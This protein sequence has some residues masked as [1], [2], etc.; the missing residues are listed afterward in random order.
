MDAQAVY[1]RLQ[2][3]NLIV[4]DQVSWEAHGLLNEIA[5]VQRQTAWDQ[6]DTTAAQL[7]GFQRRKTDYPVL[8]LRLADG[9][10]QAGRL[11]EATDSISEAARILQVRMS[12]VDKQN[13]AVA[14]L[15]EGL[16]EHF[17]HQLSDAVPAYDEARFQFRLAAQEW[18]R[19]TGSNARIEECRRADAELE[20][21]V[22]E[23]LVRSTASSS[24]GQV[25]ATP[26]RSVPETLPLT[27][28]SFSQPRRGLDR[29]VPALGWAVVALVTVAL[30][31]VSHTHG[32]WAGL[33]AFL[34]AWLGTIAA[35]LVIGRT[36]TGGEFNLR[37]PYEHA[38]VVEERGHIH[39]LGPGS[40]W[41]LIPGIRRVRATVPLTESSF[42]LRK[43]RVSLGGTS[44]RE[45]AAQVRLTIQ[46][47]YQIAEPDRAALRF[48]GSLRAKDGA[49]TP[50]G[51]DDLRAAWE[52]RL[53]TDLKPLLADE[54]WGHEA[55]DCLAQRDLI[56]ANL[57]NLLACKAQ[58]WGAN[59]TGL[60]ILDMETQ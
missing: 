19:G 39:L 32:G 1:D 20:R 9:Q 51:P 35:V 16:V 12:A 28:Q 36:L 26:W 17:S 58:A 23:V 13:R 2:P 60:T 57:R 52:A 47:N 15:Y 8:L 49:R 56:Q 18:Q 5:T 22:R 46:I 55:S 48:V 44:D 30:G 7:E 37:V 43:H 42:T 45:P 29:D 6:L 24:T 3:V 14:C 33:V 54:L 53:T 25:L 50:S 40:E 41:L 31:V 27:R 59:I 34:A 11:R 21:C 38:A 4:R 10:I